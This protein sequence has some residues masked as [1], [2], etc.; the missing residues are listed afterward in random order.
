MP[1]FVSKGSGGN[2]ARDEAHKKYIAN[3]ALIRVTYL[4]AAPSAQ[5]ADDSK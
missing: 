5:A 2:D 3:A 1:H 4:W